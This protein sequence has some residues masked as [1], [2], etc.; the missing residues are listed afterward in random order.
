MTEYDWAD[1]AGVSPV[2]TSSVIRRYL[3][4]LFL[5]VES[6]PLS[7]ESCQESLFPNFCRNRPEHRVPVEVSAVAQ[8]CF[9]RLCSYSGFGRHWNQSLEDESDG[10]LPPVGGCKACFG[11]G[12]RTHIGQV[13]GQFSGPANVLNPF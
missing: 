7:V 1:T 6:F 4:V 2:T 9:S 11:R 3:A 5:T 12:I 13:R 8:G 10:R